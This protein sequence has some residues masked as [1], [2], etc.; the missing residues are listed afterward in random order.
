MKRLLVLVLGAG[1]IAGLVAVALSRDS[2]DAARHG[3]L[4]RGAVALILTPNSRP[5][6]LSVQI[7]A[8]T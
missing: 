5:E 1:L 7:S 2:A 3:S 8:S 4:L 6:V